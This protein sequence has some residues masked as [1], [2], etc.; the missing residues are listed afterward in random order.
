MYE[1]IYLFG[2]S[3]GIISGNKISQS[4]Y[5]GFFVYNC[6]ELS[7]Y[8]NN[9]INNT[10][11]AISYYSTNIWD[12]G[13]PSGG[14]YWS[15]YTGVDANHDG[16][17]DTP[18]IIDQN[19][20]D[21][22]PLM[23]AWPDT[24]PPSTNNDYDGL[25]HTSDFTITLIA[26][27]NGSGVAKTYYRINEGPTKSIDVD[28]QPLITIEGFNNTLEFWSRDN[29]DIEELPHNLLTGIK[30]DKTPPTGSIEINNG[31]AYTTLRSVTLTINA[32]DAM[33]GV[34][35]VRYSNDGVWDTEPWE[36]PLPNKAWTLTA[37]DGTKTV[38]YQIRDNAGLISETYSDTI[39]LD[40]TAPVMQIPTREPAGYIQPD[41]PVEVSVNITD[42]ISQVKN[43]TLFYTI[44][45][46]TTWEEPIPMNFN[47]S[48]GLYEATIPG[49]PAGIWV[50][51]K[52]VAYDN[53]GNQAVNDN[54][55]NYYA[56]QVIPEFPSTIILPV[57]MLTTLVATTLLK[58]KRKTKPQLP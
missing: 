1:G 48:T 24:D 44:D 41:Q 5:Y 7:I 39:T 29:A 16:I 47:A 56:Y 9:F 54:Q 23:Y 26:A 11:S 18:Y 15:D 14:N 20:T 2:C 40:T 49:Q 31:S 25:W 35:R 8:H 36:I 13:Y 22:Y 4:Q 50:R 38:Y 43:V 51:F 55:G 42:I 17:G 30:L 6:S 45:N 53:A 32:I 46:G 19:N 33:S 21:K 52:I 34:Y 37:G 57:F 3:H 12:N 27:D 28:G 10:W 58:K